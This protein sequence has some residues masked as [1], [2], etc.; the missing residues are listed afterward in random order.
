MVSYPTFTTVLAILR[1]INKVKKKVNN[2]Q[3]HNLL[4]CGILIGIV[5]K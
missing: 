4:K 3:Y 1:K 2:R 5:T